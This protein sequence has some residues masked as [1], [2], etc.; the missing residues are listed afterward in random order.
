MAVLVRFLNVPRDRG[1]CSGRDDLKRD[2]APDF[3]HLVLKCMSLAVAG[4]VVL[5]LKDLVTIFGKLEGKYP[6]L[7]GSV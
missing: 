5:S 1:G 7:S 4:A 3:A 6:L 2:P